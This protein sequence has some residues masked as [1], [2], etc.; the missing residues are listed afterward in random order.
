MPTTEVLYFMVGIMY[1]MLFFTVMEELEEVMDALSLNHD[2]M[3]K[4]LI[5]VILKR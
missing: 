3:P 2:L 4:L 5:Y 1:Q